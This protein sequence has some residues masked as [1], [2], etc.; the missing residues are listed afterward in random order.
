[1]EKRLNVLCRNDV[2]LSVFIGNLYMLCDTPHP[3]NVMTNVIVNMVD[4]QQLTNTKCLVS[5]NADFF[6]YQSCVM[7][8]IMLLSLLLQAERSLSLACQDVSEPDKLVVVVE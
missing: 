1:M 2:T 5:V 8:L 4:T 3:K 7:C 6:L